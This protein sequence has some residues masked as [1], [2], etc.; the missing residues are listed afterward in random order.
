V[1]LFAAVGLASASDDSS[2]E[3]A[4]FKRA[5]DEITI[6]GRLDEASWLAAT[7][8]KRF[9]ET[10]PANLGSPA[11]ATTASFLYDEREQSQI[12]AKI[13]YAFSN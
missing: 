4:G 5:T 6:D 13:S 2:P 3:R 7:P 9:F 8:V 12:F 10:Y 11:V 1:S